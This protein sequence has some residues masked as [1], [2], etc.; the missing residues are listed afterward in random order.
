MGAAIVGPVAVGQEAIA[1]RLVVRLVN[2]FGDDPDQLPV[3]QHTLMRIWEH[4]QDSASGEEIDLADYEA[5]GV[6]G[7]ALSAHADEIYDELTPRQ[8]AIAETL[9]KAVTEASGDREHGV[10]RPVALG[11]VAVLAGAQVSEVEPVVDAFRRSRRSFLMPPPAVPLE[12]DSV[13]DVSHEA[14][15]RNWKRLVRWVAEERLSADYYQRVVKAAERE[16]EDGLWQN[17][18]LGIHLEWRRRQHP[19]AAWAARYDTRFGEAMDFLDRSL[20][21]QRWWRAGVLAIVALLVGLAIAALYLEGARQLERTR[22]ELE[23]V[24]TELAKQKNVEL[25]AALEEAEQQRQ[26]AQAA[27]REA[28]DARE[29]ERAARLDAEEQKEKAEA[30]RQDAELARETAEGDRSKADAARQDAEQNLKDLQGQVND[31]QGEYQFLRTGLA[32]LA[33]TVDAGDSNGPRGPTARENEG[34]ADQIDRLNSYL[35]G[36]AKRVEGVKV[37]V[38]TRLG[39]PLARLVVLGQSD[40]SRTALTSAITAVLARE[41]STRYVP[42][43]KLREEKATTRTQGVS[44][45]FASAEC[46]TA[47]RRYTIFDFPSHGDAVKGLLTGT[48]P[49]EGAILIVGEAGAPS[50]RAREQLEVA[51]RTGVEQIVVYQEVEGDPDPEA[52]AAAVQQARAL[53]ESS[54]YGGEEPTVVFGPPPAATD[55]DL[56]L[57]NSIDRLMSE[58]DDHVGLPERAIGQEFLMPI[59]DAFTISGRGTIVTGLVERGVVRVG[60]EVEIVGI[61]P[62]AKTVVIGVEMFKKLLDQGQAG[63]NVGVLLRGI[64]EEDVE[65]GQVLALPGSITPHTRFEGW[66]YL[67]TKEEGGRHTPFFSGYRPQFYFRTTDVTGVATLPEGTEMV[68]AGDNVNLTVELAAPIAM[69]KGLRFAIREAGRTV[70]V[71]VVVEI[72]E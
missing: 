60:E 42:V 46:E 17:P 3:L 50:N 49:A 5:V 71:G 65:R 38:W 61:R 45:A 68:M 24:K 58:L 67:L 34:I 22:G 53:L 25:A 52:E 32:K 39:K 70:G 59:E 2:D 47:S 40:D 44:L 37:D 10:R 41:G 54:G 21:R 64:Q 63:D 36:A 35:G 14:L 23:R 72:V 66:I 43:E 16:P 8:Q 69:E 26:A 55:D 56:T 51:R 12:P 11:E 20:R 31:V 13:L 15:M 4:W 18:R 29:D 7:R 19:T 48:V 1:H 57:R 6:R 28:E 62:T 33:E 27:T 30:A 9:F